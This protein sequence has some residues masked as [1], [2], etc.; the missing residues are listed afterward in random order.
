MTTMNYLIHYKVCIINESLNYSELITNTLVE[1]HPAH[2]SLSDWC[3]HKRLTYIASGLNKHF[4]QM[5][6]ELFDITRNHT[7]AVE[8]THFKSKVLG[9]KLPLL[10]AILR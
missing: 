7:N 9:R 2:K 8:S 4:S 3:E 5:N 1:T 10:S 6:S